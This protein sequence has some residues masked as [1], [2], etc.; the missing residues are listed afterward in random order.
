MNKVWKRFFILTLLFQFSCEEVVNIELEEGPSRLVIEASILVDKDN[1]ATSQIIR[2]TKTA[3]FYDTEVPPAEG[4]E[5][6]IIGGTGNVYVFTEVEPGYYRND[7][8]RPLLNTTYYLEI[9]YQGEVYKASEELVPVTDLEYVEQYN[10]G[11]FGGDE[12][13]L[14]AFYTD[15]VGEDNYYLFRF[16]HEDLSLQIYDDEFTDGNQTFAVF[17]VEELETGENVRFEI[18]G[19]SRRFYEYMYILRSQAGT[20]GGPFQT[21]PTI[22]R[23]NILNTTNSENFPFG[24]F[25]LSEIDNLVYTIE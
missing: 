6:T 19:I 12:I 5:V 17:S 2:L 18:Q 15:P 25:R 11:G 1:P 3:P 23:G 8:F 22:V 14:R 20:G 4:A 21:Q 16:L 13:E 10:N 9:E 7:N 24:Y